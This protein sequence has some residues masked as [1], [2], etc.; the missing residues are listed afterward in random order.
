[1]NISFKENTQWLYSP[2][3][4]NLKDTSLKGNIII[5]SDTLIRLDRSNILE[6]VLVIAPTVIVQSG[7][8]GSI[9]IIASHHIELQPNVQLNYPS[10][11]VLFDELENTVKKEDF[12]VIGQ[13]SKV[14]G[15]ICALTEKETIAMS[16]FI[17]LKKDTHVTGEVYSEFPIMLRGR[18]L[19]S[20]Y[21]DAFVDNSGGSRYINHI[22]NGKI[23]STTLPEIFGGLPLEGRTSSVV[24]WVD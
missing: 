5:K 2:N 18:I 3:E 22:Y 17:N 24:Q 1:L 6:N 11:I 12:I 23:K 9:Q 21:T 19:G 4:I 14:N 8:K 7:F 15:S 16:S 10:S 20:V 13:R